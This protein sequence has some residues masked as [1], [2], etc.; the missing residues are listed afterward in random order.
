MTEEK[1]KELRARVDAAF[2]KFDWSDLAEE[3][4]VREWDAMKAMALKGFQADVLRSRGMPEED[5]Q[6]LGL[7]KVSLEEVFK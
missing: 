6:A 5:L 1:K 4:P 3:A 7:G 2:A